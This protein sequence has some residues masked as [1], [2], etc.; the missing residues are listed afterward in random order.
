MPKAGMNLIYLEVSVAVTDH[1]NNA[2]DL[3]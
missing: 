1:R 2:H 3:S